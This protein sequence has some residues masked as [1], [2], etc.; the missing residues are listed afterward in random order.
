MDKL[1]ILIVEDDKSTQELYDRGL[2]ADVFEKHFV[3]NGEEALQIYGS[4]HPN[5]IILD[6]MLPVKSG[7]SALKEIREEIE[8]G[9]TT[10]IMATSLSGIGDIMDC[11]RLGIQGYI[12]KPF[13]YKE[14]GKKILERYYRSQTNPKWAKTVRAQHDRASG[15]KAISSLLKK[16]EIPVRAQ[17]NRA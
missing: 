17:H 11:T 4:W 5:I 7:Y 10:I 3:D 8:D 16:L 15:R 1:K 14:I 6:I 2:S 9:A 13:K 12:V